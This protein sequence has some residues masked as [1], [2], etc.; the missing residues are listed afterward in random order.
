MTLKDIFGH[1]GV[2]CYYGWLDGFFSCYKLNKWIEECLNGND[3]KDDDDDGPG[4]ILHLLD[5]A[6]LREMVKVS[7]CNIK[8]WLCLLYN[9]S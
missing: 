4:V 1:S 9:S 2:C 7:F 6:N 5:C 3:D 8:C